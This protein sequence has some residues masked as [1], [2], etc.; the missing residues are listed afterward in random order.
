[1]SNRRRITLIVISVTIG[2]VLSAFLISHKSGG[3]SGTDLLTLAFNT[4]IAVALIVAIAV[5]FRKR[6]DKE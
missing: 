4:V 5:L 2:T 6:K 3:L 1:M